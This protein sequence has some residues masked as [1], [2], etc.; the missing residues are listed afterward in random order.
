MGSGYKKI[1]PKCSFEFSSYTGVGFL[2]P[3]VYAETVQKAK[4]GKLGQELQIFFEEHNNGAINAEKV[5][6]C[7][8]RCGHL[9]NG[10][11]LTMYVPKNNEQ[12]AISHGNWCVAI[13]F[14]GAEYVSGSDLEEY[15]EEYASYPHKCEECGGKMHI[16]G[17]GEDLF[18]PQ[19][20]VP[21]ETS[22]VYMWD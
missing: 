22:E 4:E 6:L 20:K 7:C 12:G 21:I 17:D 10:K 18:C 13:P 19:C 16:V 9:A 15:Y 3:K 2:F 8:E 14:E 1:C 11:D 5:T